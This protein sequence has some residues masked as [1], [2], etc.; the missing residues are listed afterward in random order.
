MT[1]RDLENDGSER[2]SAAQQESA[3][4]LLES[5]IETADPGGTVPFRS[6]GYGPSGGELG[7]SYRNDSLMVEYQTVANAA[8]SVPDVT[9]ASSE[10]IELNDHAPLPAAGEPYGAVESSALE[11]VAGTVIGD[12]A[13]EALEPVTIWPVANDPGLYRV[14]Y[15]NQEK[16]FLYAVAFKIPLEAM[17]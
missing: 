6:T 10:L 13:R 4:S 3:R 2:P 8:D 15:E 7:F 9:A 14:G 1:N 5:V 16:E 12:A 17:Q 11:L